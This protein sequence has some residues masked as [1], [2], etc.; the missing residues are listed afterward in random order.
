[1][2]SPIVCP[3]LY[4]DNDKVKQLIEKSTVAFSVQPR[5]SH[6]MVWIGRDLKDHLAPTA[7]RIR[8]VVK[9]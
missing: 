6:R 7:V 9:M 3:L 4:I 1:M 2:I 5:K 8:T